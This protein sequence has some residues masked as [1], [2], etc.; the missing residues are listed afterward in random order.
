MAPADF[1]P[2]ESFYQQ[3]QSQNDQ[4]YNLGRLL[5]ILTSKMFYLNGSFI[6]NIVL[7]CL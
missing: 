5:D 2:S 3:K 4:S 7:A 1:N 6:V